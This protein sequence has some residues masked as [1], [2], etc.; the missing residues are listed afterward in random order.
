MRSKLFT[1]GTVLALGF[2]IAT[3]P[4]LADAARQV[5]S[6]QIKNNT[7]KSKD[8][9]DNAIEGGDVRE[10]SL[11]GLDI[12]EST[13]LLP[14]A[15]AVAEGPTDNQNHLLT[16]GLDTI[17][18]VTFVAPGAGFVKV[19]G[20]ASLDSSAA[21]NEYLQAFLYQDDT[22]I[23]GNWW[24]GG[25]NDGTY[26]LRQSIEGVSPV[27]AGPHSWTLRVDDSQPSGTG[28]T[29][30]QVIVEFFPRGSAAA[31]PAFRPGQRP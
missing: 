23:Q 7:I 24:D 15:P 20:G 8:I 25:D 2:L 6:K 31:A 21:P 14:V 3:N 13:L 1:A 11:T 29:D 12:A 30:A 5:T 16:G 27:A 22:E 17:A 19:S 26:D 28:Y 4:V 18:S 10:D 9:K